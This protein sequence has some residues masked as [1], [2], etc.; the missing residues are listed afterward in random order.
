MRGVRRN[1]NLRVVGYVYIKESFDSICNMDYFKEYDMHAQSEIGN[2]I[3]LRYLF[4][5]Q[6]LLK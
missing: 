2:S 5:R 4:N 6:Q 3:C 1:T